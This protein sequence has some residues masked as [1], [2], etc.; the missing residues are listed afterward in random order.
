MHQRGCTPLT[1]SS[2]PQETS[3]LPPSRFKRAR[4]GSRSLRPGGDHALS[5]VAADR[6]DPSYLH[7][8]DLDC[9]LARAPRR[10]WRHLYEQLD[11]QPISVVLTDA[12]GMI[13]VR[14]TGDHGAGAAP[15]PDQARPRLQLRRGHGGH[16]RHRH[17]A[18]VRRA[19]AR[20]RPRAL[21]RAAGGH[22]LRRGPGPRSGVRQDARRDRLDLLA[23]R[24]RPAD[25]LPRPGDRRPGQP[26]GRRRE[27]QPGQFGCC[28]S[29]TGP[30]GIP[31]GSCW[32][33]A[34]TS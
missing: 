34:T 11:G 10:C 18:G 12:S 23:A 28:R 29:T 13:L 26:G 7:A 17:G 16:Q 25:A 27:Q 21:R 4:C 30:A 19:R 24:C 15:G 14:L 20:L 32:R 5:N 3:S 33:S 31:A 8:P 9:P 2:P 1:I 6:L 22:G